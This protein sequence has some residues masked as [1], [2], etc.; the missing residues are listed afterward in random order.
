MGAHWLFD[1]SERESDGF[2]HR[3]WDAKGQNGSLP[4]LDGLLEEPSPEF[5][6]VD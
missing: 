3:E 1:Q 5:V 4:G 6:Q 2:E